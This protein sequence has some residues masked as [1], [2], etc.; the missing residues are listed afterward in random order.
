D[1]F[2]RPRQ[3]NLRVLANRGAS[4]IDGTISSAWG[5]AAAGASPLVL[6]TG[7]LAFY[8]DLNGLLAGQRCGLKA[9]IVL[10]NNNGGG[11]F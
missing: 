8:H 5:A 1:Q 10:I 2:A 4:G 9:T 7:D 6:V 3:A 11:I